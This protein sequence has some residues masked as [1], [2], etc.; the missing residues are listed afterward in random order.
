MRMSD[1]M[2]KQ[3]F[4]NALQAA[5]PLLLAMGRGL[6]SGQGVNA[7]MPQGMAG[8]MALQERREEDQKADAL[9]EAAANAGMSPTERALFDSMDLGGKQQFLGQ[10]MAERRAAARRGGGGSGIDPNLWASMMGG[11]VPQQA[12]QGAASMLSMGVPDT[13]GSPVAASGGLSMGQAE[14]PQQMPV[15]SQGGL[16]FGQVAQMPQQAPQTDPLARVRQIEAKI[17]QIS[18]LPPNKTTNAMLQ[19]LTGTRD[20]LLAQAERSAPA[21]PN[22]DLV[23][24]QVIDMNNPLAGA[25]DI[26]NLTPETPDDPIAELRARFNFARETLGYDT[27]QAGQWARSGQSINVNTNTIPNA[28]SGYENIFEDGKFV[29][30]QVI[31]GGPADYARQR[32]EAAAA[33]KAAEAETEANAQAQMEAVQRENAETQADTVLST[34][35]EIRNIADSKGMFDL[36]EVGIVGDALGRWGV[37]QEA[38]DVRNKVASLESAIAFDR[39]QRMR[40]ASPTGGA[41][42][43]VSERELTLLAADLGSLKTSSSKQ[44]FERVLTRVEKRYKDVMRKFAAYPNQGTPN[45]DDPLGL[46]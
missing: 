22:Y 2:P 3:G 15:P 41:L 10:L 16:S 26:P 14:A 32:D 27:Q 28:P 34:I 7:Y 23:G 29:G 35:G 31:P 19:R 37:N 17:M 44:E 20:V 21:A 9:S 38:V 24:S 45:A 43:A 12:P 36:P 46:R 8:M 5:S 1:L 6:S 11:E 30:Q 42:G 25:V 33:A 4:G 40:E 13:L 39:L 18:Q